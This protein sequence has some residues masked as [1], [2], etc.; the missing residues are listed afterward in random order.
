MGCCAPCEEVCRTSIFWRLEDADNG[1]L[2]VFAFKHILLYDASNEAYLT[3]ILSEAKSGQ[4]ARDELVHDRRLTATSHGAMAAHE[5]WERFW[6][7]PP[8]TTAAISQIRK[9]LASRPV[10]SLRISRVAQLD[11]SL[12]DQELESLLGQ[13]L[14]KAVDAL[15]VR[16][17]ALDARCAS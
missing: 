3:F 2:L 4:L 12:L 15:R 7:P 16:P 8:E 1:L 11:A 14:W 9:E 13:P 5:D 17:Y 10:P 6:V